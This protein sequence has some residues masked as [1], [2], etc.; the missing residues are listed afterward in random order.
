M[1]MLMMLIIV[2]STVD[3]HLQSDPESINF[4]LHPNETI[5]ALIYDVVDRPF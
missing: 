3:H 4:L 1:L 2:L 5:Q